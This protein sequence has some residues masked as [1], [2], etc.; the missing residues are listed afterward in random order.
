VA[1]SQ[2]HVRQ[3]AADPKHRVIIAVQAEHA[4]GSEADA[5]KELITPR[6]VCRTRG[7]RGRR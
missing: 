4:T 1:L 5:L 7:R 3:V 2:T 6:A